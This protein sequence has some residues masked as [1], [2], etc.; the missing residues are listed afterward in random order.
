MCTF[1]QSLNEWNWYIPENPAHMMDKS[2]TILPPSHYN[3]FMYPLHP[4]I[5]SLCILSFP[6]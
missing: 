2:Q 1:L 4:T 3:Q 6:L 5:A